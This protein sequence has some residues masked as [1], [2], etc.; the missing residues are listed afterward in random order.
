MAPPL[1]PA[2]FDAF[3]GRERALWGPPLIKAKNIHIE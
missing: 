2:E 1:K 3:I